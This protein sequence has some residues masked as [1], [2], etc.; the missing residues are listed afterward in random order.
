MPEL[1]VDL[2][3]VGQHTVLIKLQRKNVKWPKKYGEW[4]LMNVSLTLNSRKVK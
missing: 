4:I 2:Y 1:L 3:D